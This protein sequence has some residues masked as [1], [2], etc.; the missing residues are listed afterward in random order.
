MRIG[1]R[2]TGGGWQNTPPFLTAE[3]Q[4]CVSEVGAPRMVFVALSSRGAD[5]AQS[6]GHA[7]SLLGVRARS[8]RDE[9][10]RRSGQKSSRQVW[11]KR[12]H[13]LGAHA[14]GLR[15]EPHLGATGEREA[16]PCG[17]SAAYLDASKM[18]KKELP[19]RG[20][21]ARLLCPRCSQD[22][23][24]NTPFHSRRPEKPR[25]TRAVR[26]TVCR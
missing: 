10:H 6:H 8:E 7:C 26:A 2:V 17:S 9:R 1:S 19:K 15:E 13:F 21:A 5:G 18:Q 4:G 16:Q 11:P 24:K 22:G 3:S 20:S 12:P 23:N 14:P 25:P